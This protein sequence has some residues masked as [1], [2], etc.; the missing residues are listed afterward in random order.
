MQEKRSGPRLYLSVPVKVQ[1]P[2]DWSEFRMSQSDARALAA[3]VEMGQLCTAL[4]QHSR[5]RAGET[6]IWWG[7][8]RA[9]INAVSGVLGEERLAK[10]P[11]TAGT[12]PIWGHERV[13]RLEGT[14]RSSFLLAAGCSKTSWSCL[15]CCWVSFTARL[16]ARK[17]N[18]NLPA[19]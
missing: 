8:P 3:C 11:P 7:P 19:P 16:A 2:A 6:H 15:T 5:R 18:P 14:H 17:L 12:L 1:F 13:L 9:L 10:F 4:C